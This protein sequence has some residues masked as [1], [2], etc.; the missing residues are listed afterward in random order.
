[1]GSVISTAR[2]TA[3]GVSSEQVKIARLIIVNRILACME[4]KTVV[5][6]GAA[7]CN[8]PQPIRMGHRQ[9]QANVVHFLC[10]EFDMRMPFN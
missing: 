3:A 9:T 7:M 1:M 2:S 5:G 10:A 6:V 4:A 8:D